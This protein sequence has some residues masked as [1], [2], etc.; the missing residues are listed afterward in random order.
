MDRNLDGTRNGREALDKR[1]QKYYKEL[2]ADGL[3]LTSLMA[4]LMRRCFGKHIHHD[5]ACNNQDDAD[6]GGS[7][8]PMFKYYY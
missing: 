2:E 6:N 4:I 5:H 1:N 8:E 3:S 7:I